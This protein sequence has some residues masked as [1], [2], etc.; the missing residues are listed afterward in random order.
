MA[1]TQTSDALKILHERFY[2]GNRGRQRGLGRARAL[3]DA[4]RTAREIRAAARLTQ[5]ELAQ[6]TGLPVAL[7]RRFEEGDYAGDCLG[8]LVIIAAFCGKSIKLVVEDM[9]G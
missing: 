7:I 9:Q 4:A 2:K 8:T 5:E 6:L 1:D 3:D